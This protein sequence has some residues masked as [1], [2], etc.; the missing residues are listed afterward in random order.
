MSVFKQPFE[1][2]Q[3]AHVST[4]TAYLDP[5]IGFFPFFITDCHIP[6]MKD[7]IKF[8][9]KKRI[10]NIP[11][12]I[13]DEYYSFGIFLLNDKDGHLVSNIR[14]NHK[15]DLEETNIEILEQWLRRGG[16]QVTWWTLIQTLK[17]MELN[18]LAN[19]IRDAIP[20]CSPPQ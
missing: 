6:T 16:S 10:I 20:P 11:E 5:G 4:H 7:M 17:D 1:V 3:D 2:L 19:E 8:R 18:R 14:Y 9:G 13:G 12:E 15:D